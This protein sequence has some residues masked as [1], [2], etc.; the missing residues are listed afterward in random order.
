MSGQEEQ[1]QHSLGYEFAR[2]SEARSHAAELDR[3]F[4]R[5]E[6]LALRVYRIR[7]N[8]NYLVEA[9]FAENTSKGRVDDA[10]ALLGESGVVVHPGDL[11][12]YKRAMEGG[13]GS[14]PSWMRRFFGA[15]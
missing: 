8:G 7:W 1:R 6:L 5:E 9:T 15:S 4:T 12:D 10:R 11:A 14:L 13:F 2:E 3:R